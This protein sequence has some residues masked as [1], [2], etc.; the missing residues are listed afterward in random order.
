MGHFGFVFAAAEVRLRSASCGDG[1][2]AFLEPRLRRLAREGF[3]LG[4][5]GFM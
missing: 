3:T 1:P 2:K 5:S 4:P